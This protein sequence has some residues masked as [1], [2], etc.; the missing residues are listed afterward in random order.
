MRD[1]LNNSTQAM[2]L[3]AKR[4]GD[5]AA[6]VQETGTTVDLKGEGRKCL[7]MVSVGATLTATMVVTIQESTDDSSF[8]TL[9]EIAMSNPGAT[10]VDLA[11]TKRYIRAIITLSETGA[12]SSVYND[13]SVGA[14]IY[15]ER[16]IPSNV[17]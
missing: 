2:L 3:S 5:G 13:A 16:F 17:A 10:V 7:V 1:L 4:R 12:I 14:L 8:T 9:Q 15:N 11:P 6:L